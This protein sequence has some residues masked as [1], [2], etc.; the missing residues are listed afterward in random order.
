MRDVEKAA[1]PVRL[2]EEENKMVFWGFLTGMSLV[3]PLLMIGLGSAF[4]RGIPRDRNGLF[5]YRTKRSLESDEAWQLAHSHCGKSWGILGGFFCLSLL[6]PWLRSQERM[7]KPLG[8]WAQCF[9]S[10]RLLS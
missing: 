10:C 6:P 4:V 9:L 8:Q 5:G 2:P 1:V 7:R 3:L